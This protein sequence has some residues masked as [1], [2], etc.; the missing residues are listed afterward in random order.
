MAFLLLGIAISRTQVAVLLFTGVIVAILSRISY[1]LYLHPLSSF[2][3]L[4]LWRATRIPWFIESQTCVLP[5][6]VLELHK[7]YGKIIRIAPDEVSVMDPVAWKEFSA[8]EFP[9]HMGHYRPSTRMPTNITFANREEH[10]RL[11]RRL[12]S[13]FSDRTMG[14][15]EPI[16]GSYVDL[17]M[18][19]LNEKCDK[20]STALNMRDWYS[21][22]TFDIIGDLAFGES[23]DCLKNSAY[24]A[25]VENMPRVVRENAIVTRLGISGYKWFNGLIIDWGLMKSRRY[26]M[27]YTTE[28]VKRRMNLG[29]ERPD[30]IEGLISKPDD[31]ELG[32]LSFGE[33]VSTASVLVL[34]GSVNNSSLLC[35]VTYFLVTNPE[36]LKKLTEEV[37]G[38][39]KGQE[40]TTLMSVNTDLPYMLACLNEALRLYSPVGGAFPRLVP[41]GGV[42]V[43]NNLSSATDYH[44]TR[45]VVGVFH[46]AMY[47]DPTLW[48]DP[49]TFAPERFL[50]D[51]KYANG[52]R[53]AFEPFS[54]GPRNCV[55][56]S[57]V[58]AEMR[59]ILTK[60]I[61][62]FDMNIAEDSKNRLDQ[63]V[64]SVWIKPP[65]NIYLKPVSHNAED[66]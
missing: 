52:K 57:L 28:K 2:P 45:T 17:L 27:Q 14:S 4:M 56:K 3:G 61:F 7:K 39:F 66:L 44:F 9:H 40:D 25:W 53:D 62:S 30:L 16:I 33:I 43:C 5:Y 32:Q 60:I 15:Q 35:G 11:R 47:H 58:Y 55:G 63:K 36:A 23:F 22:T 18:K 1:R 19:R 50:G 31:D 48:T 21:W 29:I 13:G 12:N 34:A 49:E 8:R 26:Q 64:F 10:A 54:V 41:K 59:L 65:L 20:G 6:R 37:R 51:P 46:Y 24:H 38:P 42:T